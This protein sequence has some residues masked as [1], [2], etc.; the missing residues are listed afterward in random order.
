MDEVVEDGRF[1]SRLRWS[2]GVGDDFA[3]EMPGEDDL[4]KL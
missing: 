2:V 3:G 4:Y 1:E